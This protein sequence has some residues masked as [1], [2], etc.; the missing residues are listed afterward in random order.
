[1]SAFADQQFAPNRGT[2]F[3]AFLLSFVEVRHII[4]LFCHQ[5]LHP[6]KF[7]YGDDG[8]VSSLHLGELDLTVIL[9]F[10]LL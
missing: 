7:F 1:M 2:G 10:F 8:F 5:L 9:Y 6:F 3:L 4:C